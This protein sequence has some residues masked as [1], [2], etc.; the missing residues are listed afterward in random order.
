MT[1]DP[2]HPSEEKIK[3]T[4]ADLDNMVSALN[5]VSITTPSIAQKSTHNYDLPMWQQSL[6]DAM[7]QKQKKQKLPWKLRQS[8]HHRLK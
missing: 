4:Q 2:T 8:V 5:S 1:T 7:K 6:R 3:E